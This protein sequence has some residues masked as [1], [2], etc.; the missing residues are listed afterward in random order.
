MIILKKTIRVSLLVGFVLSLLFYCLLMVNDEVIQNRTA[1]YIPAL[2]RVQQ[3]GMNA[4]H[5][6]FPCKTDKDN[7]GCEGYKT[8][9][10]WVVVNWFVYAG[11]LVLP[12]WIIRRWTTTLD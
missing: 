10:A 4:A 12:L 5:S 7:S 2:L 9:P 11:L 3:P 8:V 6:W 1:S